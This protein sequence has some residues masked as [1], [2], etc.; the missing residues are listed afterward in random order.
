MTKENEVTNE[1]AI[2]ENYPALMMTPEEFS[3]VVVANIGEGETISFT[4]LPIIKVPSGG[5][6]Q[7]MVPGID[8]QELV[9]EL[10]GI[11]VY[12][13][14]HRAYWPKKQEDAKTNDPLCASRDAKTGIVDK[15]HP[16]FALAKKNGITGDC[17]TCPLAQFGSAEKGEGQACKA[18]RDIFL[19]RPGA[20]LPTVISVPPTSIKPHKQFSVQVSSAGVPYFGVQTGI[21]LIAEKN[22]SGTDFCRMSFQSKGKLSQD[23]L[24]RARGYHQ[25]IKAM[26]EATNG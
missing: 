7:W 5:I 23:E 11:I 1:L 17:S 26:L 6:N 14:S 8:G 20:M 22:A 21:S 18:M 9:K 19:L 3:E 25:T 2:V 13:R 10:E 4:D 12:W 15:E 16:D 24:A